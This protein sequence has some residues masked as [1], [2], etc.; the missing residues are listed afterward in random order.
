MR[1]IENASEI[2]SMDGKPYRAVRHEGDGCSPRG[3]DNGEHYIQD[4][5]SVAGWL[6]QAFQ[7]PPMTVARQHF[8]MQDAARAYGVM[9]ACRRADERK[10]AIRLED[11]DWEWLRSTLF[12]DKRGR[13][14]M[15]GA[16]G[17]DGSPV[18]VDGA[19]A[20]QIYDLW[21]ATVLH[22][23][24]EGRSSDLIEDDEDDIARANGVAVGVGA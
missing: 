7:S 9:R 16:K 5:L 2:L 19:L 15:E 8:T 12:D 14:L 17:G 1:T 3:C 21:L 22:R 6:Q 20:V 23:A 13:E 24:V 11:A 18:K 10:R 4:V